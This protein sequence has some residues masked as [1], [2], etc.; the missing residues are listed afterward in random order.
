[1]GKSF[2]VFPFTFC[3][4]LIVIEKSFKLDDDF[5]NNRYKQPR[6]FVS[7]LITTNLI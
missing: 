6:I 7:Q 1:M 5:I 2:N 3:L 4:I